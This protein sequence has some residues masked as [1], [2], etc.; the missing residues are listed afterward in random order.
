IRPLQIL[1]YILFA[2][3]FYTLLATCYIARY[4]SRDTISLFASRI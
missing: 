3:V 2:T 4:D 1:H